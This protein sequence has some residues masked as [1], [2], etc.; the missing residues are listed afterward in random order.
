MGIALLAAGA[1]FSATAVWLAVRAV[2]RRERWTKWALAVLVAAPTLYVLSY[3]PACHLGDNDV[4]SAEQ[5]RTAYLPVLLVAGSRGNL[6]RIAIDRYAELCGGE[7]TVTRIL[8][9][10]IVESLATDDAWIPG[11]DGRWLPAPSPDASLESQ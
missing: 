6:G 10:E 11:L 4:L 1:V 2:N 3:G 9:Q 5:I 8:L 7:E